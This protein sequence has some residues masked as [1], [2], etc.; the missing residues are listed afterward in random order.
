[1]MHVPLNVKL[2]PVLFLDQLIGV[3]MP[4]INN[5]RHCSRFLSY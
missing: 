2:N 3:L 1:M 5:N 4:A